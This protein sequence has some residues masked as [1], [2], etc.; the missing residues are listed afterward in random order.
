MRDLNFFE[1]YV[2]KKQF[3]F[4]KII[5]LYFL[6]IL[7]VIGTFA[8]GIYNQNRISTLEDQ[9]EDRLE[10]TEN[11]KIVDKVN[12]IKEL[13]KEL[14]TFKEEVDKIIELDKKIEENNI[15]GEELLY[16]IKSRMPDGLFLTSFTAKGR[17]VQI[18]GVA[19]DAYSIAEFS[20]GIELIENI[21]SI[22]V[23]NINNVDNYQKFVLNLTFQDVNIDEDQAA[24][25]S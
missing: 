25:D 7:C 15:I 11:L 3:K 2:E 1:S 22:F 14:T 4:D 13:E 10:V 9:I 21:E 19:T 24:E 16:D 6:L 8:N 5:I 20:K 18:A 17:N 12:V 23:S